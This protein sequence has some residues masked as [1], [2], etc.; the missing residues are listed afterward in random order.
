MKAK[1][2]FKKYKE[3]II[4]SFAIVGAIVLVLVLPAI[5][6]QNTDLSS[7]AVGETAP[8]SYMMD[9]YDSGSVKSAPS[10]ATRI[11][12]PMVAQVEVGE[13]K[14]V[15]NGSISLLVDKAES[16]VDQIKNIADQLGGFVE[17]SS[18]YDSPEIIYVKTAS[19]KTN[20]YGNITIRVPSSNFDQA[21]SGIKALAIKVEKDSTNTRDVSAEYV[22]MEAQL[23]NLR[24]EEEQYLSIMKKAVK[25]E[26]ILNVSSRLADV[27]GRIERMQAQFNFLS[28]QIDMSTI[29]VDLRAEAD[30]EGVGTSWR[31][32][33][34]AKQAIQEMLTS[35]VAYAD[36]L[37]MFIINIP[38]LLLR[39]LITI[40][41]LVGWAL[42]LY[43]VWK[44][45]N[46]LKARFLDK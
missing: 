18:L 2:F 46:Y 29:S 32:V 13:R 40:I 12:S 4:N 23:K 22:D 26:D 43:L 41:W 20:K 37:I 42:G 30:I 35:L 21:V 11:A 24:L 45:I 31:P 6:K 10:Y 5:F 34:V 15:R 1:D 19:Q 27:R 17:N 14:V 8:G 39:V 28:K 38:I 16:A 3:R 44:I 33:S 36:G 9:A 25:V 7:Q